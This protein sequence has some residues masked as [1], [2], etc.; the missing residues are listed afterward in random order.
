MLID[1]NVAMVLVFW[2]RFPDPNSP[3]AFSPNS[4]NGTEQSSSVCLPLV[5]QSDER[6]ESVGDESRKPARVVRSAID[7]QPGS[8]MTVDP[9]AWRSLSR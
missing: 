5:D 7:D 8:E 9:G 1:K 2:N 4:T 6:P 3:R